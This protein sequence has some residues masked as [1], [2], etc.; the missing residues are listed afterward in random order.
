MNI[1]NW[2]TSL[3]NYQEK[4]RAALSVDKERDNVAIGDKNNNV[5]KSAYLM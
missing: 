3:V 1:G 2:T 5:S 4:R